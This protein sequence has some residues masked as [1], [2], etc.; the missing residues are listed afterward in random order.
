MLQVG[1]WGKSPK[2]HFRIDPS[3]RVFDE[4]HHLLL[5]VESGDKSRSKEIFSFLQKFI[6]IFV[7]PGV[8]IYDL[9]LDNEKFIFR[10]LPPPIFLIIFSSLQKE[11]T[12]KKILVSSVLISVLS[13]LILFSFRKHEKVGK[14]ANFYFLILKLF[15]NFLYF[16]YT[17]P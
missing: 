13:F 17:P 12:K 9:C 2:L 3:R 5:C 1:I 8:V 7:I 16:Y 11:R 6:G 15:N 10:D 14:P 4:T